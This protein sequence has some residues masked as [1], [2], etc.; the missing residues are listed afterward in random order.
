MK[1]LC[2]VSMLLSTLGAGAQAYRAAATG[3]GAYTTV[4]IEGSFF[5]GDYGK[6]NLYGPTIV[7]DTHLHRYVGIEAEARFL[8]WGGKQGVQQNTYLA[9]PRYSFKPSGWV[10]YVKM[11]VGLGTMRFPYGYGNGNYFVMAPGAGV[12]K[13]IAHDTVRIRVVDLEYQV[14]PQFTFG[15]LKP[16][17]VSTGISFRVW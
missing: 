12:E 3:P 17:G 13:W 15:T 11:P 7:V 14:W 4:G 6:V 8:R 5:K 9:G 2:V 10:P 1:L 16:Y